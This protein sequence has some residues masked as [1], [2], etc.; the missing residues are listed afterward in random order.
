MWGVPA[1]TFLLTQR[2]LKRILLR[3]GLKW[4]RFK[5]M[6]PCVFDGEKTKQRSLKNME[7]S[8]AQRGSCCGLE[9]VDIYSFITQS[10]FG[11]KVQKA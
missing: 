1:P 10:V 5:A 4:E 8:R 6:Y 7:K 9:F 11:Q 3:G 2:E